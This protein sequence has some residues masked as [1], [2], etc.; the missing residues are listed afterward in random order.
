MGGRASRQ[1]GMRGEYSA[2]DLFRSWGWE[3]DRVP[4]SGAAQGFKGDLRIRKNGL[5]LKV[6]VKNEEASYTSLYKLL[7]TTGAASLIEAP[8]MM[9]LLSYNFEDLGLESGSS[10][11]KPVDLKSPGVKKTIGMYALVKGCD[12]LMVKNN[13]KPFIY[14]R[15]GV[16][17]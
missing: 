2:R 13:N 16:R 6:E 4:A 3:A 10:F 17:E 14:I 9:V 15:Y 1:K 8:N 7:D 5:E 11:A 12:F